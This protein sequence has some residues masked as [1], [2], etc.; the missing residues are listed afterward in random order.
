MDFATYQ[1][2]AAR[3]LARKPLDQYSP[4]EWKLK[5]AVMGLGIAGEAGEVADMVKKH[6]GHGHPL[7]RD[8]LVEELGDVLWY[9]AAIATL[10]GLTLGDVATTN[11]AKLRLRYPD[12]F[13]E[14]ASLERK[15]QQE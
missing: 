3:T 15:D 12:G 1:Q 6:V 13:S 9:V 10:H 5:Q 2:Q 11:V 8:A 14:A 7:D 4:E